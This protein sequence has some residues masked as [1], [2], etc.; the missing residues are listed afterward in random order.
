MG[1][2]SHLRMAREVTLNTM[3][4]CVNRVGDTGDWAGWY[5]FGKHI[6]RIYVGDGGRE[7]SIY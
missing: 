4:C 7:C 3:G 1:E 2:R 6:Y 5:A